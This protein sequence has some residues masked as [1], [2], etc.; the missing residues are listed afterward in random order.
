MGAKART[1]GGD[2]LIIETAGGGYGDPQNRDRE[3]LR[4][5]IVQGLLSPEEA[6]EVY[7]MS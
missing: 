3:A 7:G 1:G 5:E 4:R 6:A 2:R